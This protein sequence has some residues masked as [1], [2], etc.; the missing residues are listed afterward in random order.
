MLGRKIVSFLLLAIMGLG[1]KAQTTVGMPVLRVS[2]EGKF[3]KGMDYVFGHMQLTDTDGSVIELPA[4][5]KTRGATAASYMMKPSFNMKLRTADNSEELDSALLGMRSCSSW[6]LDGMA[7]DRICMRNRI[8]FDIWNEFSRLPYDTEFGGRC[9]T[10]GRFLEVYINDQYY[11][12]YCLNDRINRKLLDLK[13]VKEQDDGSVLVRGVLYK[14]GT[15]S[16]ANQ[17]DP[18]Y[19]E[20]STACVVSWH[21][22]WEISYPEDYCGQMTWQPLLDAFADGNSAAYIKKYFFL[23]NLADYQIHVMA[24]SIGDNWGNKNHFLSVR[25]INKDINDPDVTQ[26]NRRRFVLIPWDLD[27]SLGGGYDGRYYDGNYSV[28]PVADIGKNALYPISPVI[29]DAEYQAILKRRWKEGR[30]AAFSIDSINSKL[31]RY[32]DLFLNSG[33][34]QRMVDYFESKS[35]KPNYVIDLSQEI[36]HIK[37]WYMNRFLEMDAYFGITEEDGIM[38]IDNSQLTIDN[39]QFTVDNSQLGIKGPVYDLIGRRV[40]SPLL[41]PHSSLKK[42]LYIQDGKKILIQ[43]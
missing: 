3:N 37:T 14:S 1:L 15:N 27:T 28:W 34:W 6:I 12:I 31:D 13:K 30:V 42:G 23:E 32:R 29:G 43:R 21:N 26:A 18:G 36:E 5:F 10:E 8:A 7:I 22:A 9:G 11:G 40:D 17:N 33:A 39:S 19:N 38:T 25:N 20:D 4:K 41:T 16:I 2:F 24:L 35:S